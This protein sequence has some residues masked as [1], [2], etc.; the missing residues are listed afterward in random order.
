MYQYP[1][2]TDSILPNQYIPR[3]ADESSPHPPAQPH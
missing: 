2:E 1:S 3:F